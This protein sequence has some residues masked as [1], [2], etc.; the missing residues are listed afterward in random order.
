[1]RR[2]VVRVI[3]WWLRYRNW[4]SARRDEL[5]KLQATID[6][7]RETHRREVERLATDIQIRD[8]AIKQYLE[9]IAR[10]RER[11]NAERAIAIAQKEYAALHV[12]K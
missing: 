6:T 11:V 10:D 2:F 9:I 12:A 5:A 4:A 8:D 3:D 1:M 7:L